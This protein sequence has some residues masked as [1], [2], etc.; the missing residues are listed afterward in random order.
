MK[1]SAPKYRHIELQTTQSVRSRKEKYLKKAATLN[2][3]DE[4]IIEANKTNFLIKL[5]DIKSAIYN[6]SKKFGMGYYPHDGRVIIETFDNKKR[7]FIILGNQSGESIA[8]LI[9]T[10]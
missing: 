4:S 10:K 5:S 8:N 2:L 3:I 1:L 9:T 6:P 7:E